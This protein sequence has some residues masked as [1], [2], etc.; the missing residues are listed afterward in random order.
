MDFWI[1]I[2]LISFGIALV[3]TGAII[4]EILTIAFRR[5]LFDSN[6][7]RHVHKGLVPRLGGIAFFPTVLCSMTFVVGYGM[8]R[9]AGAEMHMALNAVAMQRVRGNA[10]GEVRVLSM[11]G[12][13]VA[14]VSAQS[15]AVID[16]AG[17]PSGVY[18][19]CAQGGVVKIIK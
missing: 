1:E 11:A 10:L 17:L 5:Q 14:A 6:S 8:Q 13:T 3:L 12:A 19:V 9:A 15:E 2:A 4:P 7:D 16:M 18:L